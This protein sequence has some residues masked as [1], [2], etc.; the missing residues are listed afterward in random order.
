MDP[1]I[2]NFM[3]KCDSVS[4]KLRKPHKYHE[5]WGQKELRDL[6]SDLM[7][8]V[9]DYSGSIMNVE[10]DECRRRFME[11]YDYVEN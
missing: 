2:V 6:Q 5:L 1:K 7:S 4:Q 3:H 11:V 9:H 10:K 8:I